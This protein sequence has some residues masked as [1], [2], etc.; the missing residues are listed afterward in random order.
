MYQSILKP[1]FRYKHIINPRNYYKITRPFSYNV[2]EEILLKVMHFVSASDVKGDYLEFGVFQG[3]SFIP[4]YHIGSRLSKDMKFYAFDSFEG[5]P[6]LKGIDKKG[7]SFYKG[8]FACSLKRFKSNL[9]NNGVDLKKVTTVKG[10]YDKVLNNATKKKLPIKRASVIWVD[11]DLYEST[12]PVLKFITDYVVDGTV[13]V[14]DDWYAYKSNPN[15]GEQR[16]FKEWLKKNPKI[17]ATEYQQ[18][19]VWGLSFVLHKS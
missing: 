2:K 16:A 7:H 14:F 17:T 1:S 6:D 9:R 5:L 18:Y 4:A 10:W 19:G 15:K 12:V 13:I 11:C 8:K 3:K